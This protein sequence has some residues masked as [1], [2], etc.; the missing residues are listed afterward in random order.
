M[1]V[2]PDLSSRRRPMAEAPI[3]LSGWRKARE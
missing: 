1:D 3:V 2:I